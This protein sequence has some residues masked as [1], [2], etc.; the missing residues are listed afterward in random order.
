[1]AL[2]FRESIGLRRAGLSSCFPPPPPDQLKNAAMAA[3]LN[4]TM[5]RATAICP[6]PCFFTPAPSPLAAQGVAALVAIAVVARGI[7]RAECRKG[8]NWETRIAAKRGMQMPA[9]M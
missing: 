9:C 7:Q 3:N 5:R 2:G 8:K 6:R 1:M 4:G